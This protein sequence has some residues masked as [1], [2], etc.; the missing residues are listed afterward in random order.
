MGRTEMFTQTDFAVSH[1]YKFGRDNRYV[2]A[3]DLN[4]LNLFDEENETSIFNTLSAVNVPEG[5]IST[6]TPSPCSIVQAIN[7]LTAGQLYT[8]VNNY[9]NGSATV[10]N[11]KD[12]RYG[13]PNGFQGPRSVRFG[14]RFIF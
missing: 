4:I 10:L 14:F 3:A 12:N 8:P 2:L 5:A 9:L 6:C 7:Q 11:R 1:K 13:Q